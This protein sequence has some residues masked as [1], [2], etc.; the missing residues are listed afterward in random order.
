MFFYVCYVTVVLGVNTNV[1]E[2]V[3]FVRP[4]IIDYALTCAPLQQGQSN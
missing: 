1:C 3:A 2:I 4:S